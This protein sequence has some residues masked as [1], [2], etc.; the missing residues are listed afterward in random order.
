[1]L[2]AYNTVYL[3]VFISGSLMYFGW[4]SLFLARREKLD[5]KRFDITS[6]NRSKTMELLNGICEIKINNCGTQKI[7]EWEELQRD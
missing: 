4:L 5:F 2:F 7:W 1:M 6:Q 3:C